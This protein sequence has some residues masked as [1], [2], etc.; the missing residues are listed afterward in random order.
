M[1]VSRELLRD[2]RER[3]RVVHEGGG[4]DKAEARHKKG[5]LTA[6]ERIAILFQE[7]TF[8]E[9]GRLITHRARGFGM[10]DK[11]IP[12]DGIVVGTGFV[13]GRQVATFSQDFTVS[14][15]TLGQMHAEKMVSVMQ[16]ALKMGVPLIAFKDSGGARIQEGVDALSGY[17]R[18]FYH[19]VL[20]SG[21]VPQI[22]I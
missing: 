22:A 19:N 1:T 20:L 11:V 3:R 10:A 2:L 7:G 13:D 12:A 5:Q 14:A 8:Q 21:V 9:I 6:R 17:G 4:R 16:Y 18:V 15:G